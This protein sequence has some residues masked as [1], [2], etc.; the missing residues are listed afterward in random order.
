MSKIASQFVILWE[1]RVRAKKRRSFEKAYAPDG[2]WGTFFR[3]GKGYIRTKLIR[4]REDPL[5]YVTIDVWE[6]RRDYDSFKKQNRVEYQAIDKE[7]ESLTT[8]EKLIGEFVALGAVSPA[9]QQTATALI[10]IATPQ[11]VSWMVAL[12]RDSPSAAHWPEATYR[13]AFGENAPQR[14]ALVSADSDGNLNGFVIAGL[15]AD[16]CE[17]ENIVVA[18]KHQNHLIG[19]RLLQSLASEARKQNAARIFLEVRESN[20]PARALYE[21]CGFKIAGRRP[22]Y[23][24][25]PVEDAILYTLQL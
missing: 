18:R 15:A 14:I 1:F 24:T 19:S 5:R 10:R 4:D 8:I 23:Y 16:D 25:A 17:L 22:S 13:R 11:D 20:V 6:S 9:D 7:C 2:L 21:K 3:T 12:E